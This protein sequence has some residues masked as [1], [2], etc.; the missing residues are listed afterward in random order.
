MERGPVD[1]SQERFA[2]NSLGRVGVATE[3]PLRFDFPGPLQ[4]R[5]FLKL[6]MLPGLRLFQNHLH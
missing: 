2:E 4:V 1:P 6:T 5:I 3:L